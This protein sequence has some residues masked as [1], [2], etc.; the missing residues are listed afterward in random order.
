[1]DESHATSRGDGRGR[2]AE[3]GGSPEGDR[4]I[5]AHA[6]IRS[7][8]STMPLRLFAMTPERA[9]TGSTSARGR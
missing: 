9:R 6:A 8:N 5:R 7:L 2:G 3:G 1:M 4:S